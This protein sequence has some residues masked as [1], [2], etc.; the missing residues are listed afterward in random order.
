M[1]VIEIDAGR[2]DIRSGGT[3]ASSTSS[4][5]SGGDV[6]VTADEVFLDGAASKITATSLEIADR[7][8]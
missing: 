7:D 2:I 3:I 1:L 8:R 5:G 6:R 4:T